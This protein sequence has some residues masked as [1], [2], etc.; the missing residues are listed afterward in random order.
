M[1]ARTVP[2]S[3]GGTAPWRQGKFDGQAVVARPG[4]GSD[5]DRASRTAHLACERERAEGWRVGQGQ[6][7]PAQPTDCPCRAP[8]P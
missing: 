4:I 7:S 1:G 8:R 5:L 6:A 3:R 2:L